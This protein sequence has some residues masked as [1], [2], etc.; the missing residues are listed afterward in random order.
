[1]NPKYVYSHL[2]ICLSPKVL[3]N[4]AGK[5]ASSVGQPCMAQDGK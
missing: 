3:C 5:I 1:M 2:C 4:I